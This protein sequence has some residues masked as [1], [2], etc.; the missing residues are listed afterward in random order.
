MQ[1][2]NG[3]SSAVNETV[4]FSWQLDNGSS[5][6]ADAPQH[7]SLDPGQ[8]QLV[9]FQTPASQNTQLSFQGNPGYNNSTNC[10]FQINP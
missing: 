8:N 10:A 7:V 2:T 4:T 9:F 5:V 6:N 3:T 1:V